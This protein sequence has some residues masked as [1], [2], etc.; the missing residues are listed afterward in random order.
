MQV[1][2]RTRELYPDTEVIMITGYATVSTAVEA[3]QRGAY[4]YLPKPYKIDEV[5]ILVR[6][7]L[8]KRWLRLE[9]TDLKRQ[10]QSQ[11]GVPLLIGKS[12]QMEA[13]K[14]DHRADRP[15]R[16][17][18]AHPGG[19]RHR[20]GTGGQGHPPPEPPGRQALPGHQLRRLQRGAAGQRALRPRKRGLHRGPGRQKGA[21]GSGRR[22]HRSSWTKSAKCRC[23]CR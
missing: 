20:Q 17:H 9:V 19:D 4:H 12:P 16:R 22:G 8:E 23:P 11:K 3:M 13:L 14:A 15:H 10:V 7:A 18:G 1:L 21:A 2:E 6:K 5:R